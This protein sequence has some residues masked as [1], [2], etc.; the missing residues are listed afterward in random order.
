MPMCMSRTAGNSGVPAAHFKVVGSTWVP[1]GVI[2]SAPTHFGC[3]SRFTRF[4]TAWESSFCLSPID[5]ELSIMKR[6]S[7]W[8]TG[9]S[10]VASK[11]VFT[12][13]STVAVCRSRQPK[14]A[15]KSTAS[16]HD[17]AR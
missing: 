1:L 11:F 17:G 14:A 13:G 9:D 4:G 6:M 7:T 8:S 16:A 10:L 15:T 3:T 2:P 5:V 12:V